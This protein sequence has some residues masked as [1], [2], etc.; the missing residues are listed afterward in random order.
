MDKDTLLFSFGKWVAP[1]NSLNFQEKVD[2]LQQD[3]YVKKL[4]TASYIL[5]FFHAQLSRKNNRVDA[6]ILE[7]IFH[8]LVIQ[9]QGYSPS[10]MSSI[11]NLKVIDSSTISL[12]LSQFKWAKFRKTKAGIKLHL[13]LV[14]MDNETVYPEKVIVTSASRNDRT[15][16]EFLIDEADAMYVFDRGYVDYEKFD[17]YCDQGIFFASRLKKNAVIHTLEAFT[18]PEERNPI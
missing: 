9:I 7:A 6:D 11:R 8:E 18:L 10:R 3:K 12:C 13:R 5:L 14:F 2:E 4:T 16:M 17:T 1:I 15:Q